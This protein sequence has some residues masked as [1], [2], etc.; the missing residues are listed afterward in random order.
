MRGLLENIQDY[1]IGMEKR[2]PLDFLSRG[3]VGFPNIACCYLLFVGNLIAQAWLI[4]PK[5]GLLGLMD[6]AN[7]MLLSYEQVQ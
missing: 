7:D 4:N 5:P 3:T 6:I 1:T 2:F